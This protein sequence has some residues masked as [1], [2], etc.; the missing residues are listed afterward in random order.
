MAYL[1]VSILVLI[2]RVELGTSSLPRMR[3][4]DWAIWAKTHRR[5]LERAAGIEPASSAWKAE[6]LPLNYTRTPLITEAI[7]LPIRSHWIVVEGGGFEPPKAEPSDLQSDPFGRSGTPPK[8]AGYSLVFRFSC[9]Q[10]KRLAFK[11]FF[12]M[13][14]LHNR[15]VLTTTYCRNLHHYPIHCITKQILFFF[16]RLF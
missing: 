11:F 9:Q 7:S 10:R 6:V 14:F 8:L 16:R 5:I 13:Q 3:S 2:P 4:T 1:V 15:R 12:R